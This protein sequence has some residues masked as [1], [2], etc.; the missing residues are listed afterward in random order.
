MRNLTHWQTD[1][2]TIQR[3][4][5]RRWRLVSDYSDARADALL[6]AERRLYELAHA[7]YRAGKRLFDLGEIQ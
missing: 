7:A 4:M 1:H 5:R 3:I 6:A 2:A